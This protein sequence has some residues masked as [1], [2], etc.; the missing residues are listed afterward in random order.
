MPPAGADDQR[1]TS[2]G[3]EK[4]PLTDFV[5]VPLFRTFIKW[6]RME[7]RTG[8]MDRESWFAANR[9]ECVN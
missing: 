2:P 7:E 4:R 5:Q 1:V 9:Y 8:G 3:C 6:F